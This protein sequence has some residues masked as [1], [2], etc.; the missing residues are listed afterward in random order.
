MKT[1]EIPFSR[2][3]EDQVNLGLSGGYITIKEDDEIVFQF[4]TQEQYQK[5]L[6]LKNKKGGATYGCS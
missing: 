6:E 2:L 3:R 4:D 5:Y 1:V